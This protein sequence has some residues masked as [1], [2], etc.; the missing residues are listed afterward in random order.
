MAGHSKFANI[1]HKKEKNDAKKA[2]IFTRFGK[3]IMVAVKEGG[4]DI[5]ANSRLREVVSKAK[6]NNMPND[7][8]ERLIK[9]ASGDKTAQNYEKI[10]YEG[11]GV[12]GIAVIVEVLTDNRNRTVANVRNAFT[13][14]N[15]NMGVSGCVSFMFIEKGL[16]I[17]EKDNDINEEQLMD[18]ALEAGATDFEIFD[19]YIEISTEPSDFPNVFEILKEKNVNIISAEVGKYP[20]NYV[21]LENEDDIKKMNKLINLLDDD[22]DVQNVFHNWEE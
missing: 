13:K 8:I 12:Q 4:K 6:A 7:N 1:K 22:E 15:G 5:T 19:E 2:K 20:E 14:G 9:K 3:E 21:K 16:I 10:V 11:Y 18:I 17:L